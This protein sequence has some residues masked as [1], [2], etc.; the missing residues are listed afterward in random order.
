MYAHILSNSVSPAQA[1]SNIIL[2]RTLFV[3]NENYTVSTV[4]FMSRYA[5]QAESVFESKIVPLRMPSS[6]SASVI[7]T[8]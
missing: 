1:T 8:G 6:T 3:T 5:N 4:Y 7:T 2:I